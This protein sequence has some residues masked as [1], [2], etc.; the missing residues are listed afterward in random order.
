MHLSAVQR[1]NV[2]YLLA[3]K[4]GEI[5]GFKLFT[6]GRLNANPKSGTSLIIWILFLCKRRIRI[7]YVCDCYFFLNKW[8]LWGKCLIG[9]ECCG[10]RVFCQLKIGSAFKIKAVY[11]IILWL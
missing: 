8:Q 7:K 9:L 10:I 3:V 5:L 1:L 6:D 11:S 2:C 4:S